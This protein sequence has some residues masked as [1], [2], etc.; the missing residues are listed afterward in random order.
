[1]TTRGDKGVFNG[2]QHQEEIDMLLRGEYKQIQIVGIPLD[3][4]GV[5]AASGNPQGMFE[6]E[7]N[8]LVAWPTF[9]DKDFALRISS[10]NAVLPTVFVRFN[11]Q[12][13]PWM[14]I[15][16]PNQ[17]GGSS[18]YPSAYVLTYGRFWVYNR[19]AVPG[20]VLYLAVLKGVCC[21]SNGNIGPV[22][23]DAYQSPTWQKLK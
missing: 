3:N 21:Y 22:V 5:V 17:F 18:T 10:T 9:L 6:M 7:G 1:M 16:V 23:I 15:G 19:A 12:E 14:P 4:V 2:P 13:A 11:H 20:A 8:A